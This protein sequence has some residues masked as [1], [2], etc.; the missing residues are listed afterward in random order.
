MPRDRGPSIATIVLTLAGVVAVVALGLWA[1]VWAVGALSGPPA[2]SAAVPVAAVATA[3][4]EPTAASEPA[5]QPVATWTAPKASVRPVPVPAAAK[6][7]ATSAAGKYVVVIDA[8]HQAQADNTPEPIGP[9]SSETKPAVA[10]GATGATTG[11]PEHTVNLQVSL[12]LRDL[13]QARGVKVVMVRTTE[14]V[15]IPNSKRAQTAND[16]HADLFVRV[17]CDDVSGSS[18][19]G[20]LTV[21]PDDNQ[22]THPI[23][24][25]SARAGQAIQKAT[26][27]T[28]GAYDR[29][30]RP[31]DVPMSGFNWSKVPTV[32]VEMGLMSNPAEDR[33]L[34]DP[35]YQGKLAQGMA[36]GVM[37]YLQGGR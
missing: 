2:G 3:S 22:W 31:P 5:T 21:I 16:A 24:A 27:A 29:G 4:V 25:A 37:N 20:L 7:A 12:K 26:L 6:S 14:N 18:T 19:H 28:T 30:V 1:V 33:L 23:V 8:G 9:G 36:D 17:H 32:I 11:V 35:S 10:S 13:L 34:S 15:D